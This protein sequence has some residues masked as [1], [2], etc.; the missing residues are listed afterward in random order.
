MLVNDPLNSLTFFEQ[1]NPFRAF[2]EICLARSFEVWKRTWISCQV[3][4]GV[5]RCDKV[6]QCKRTWIG[7]QVWQGECV[8][9]SLQARCA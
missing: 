9:W 7:G 8:Q 1:T 5:T 6:W 4:Q 2:G 3:W